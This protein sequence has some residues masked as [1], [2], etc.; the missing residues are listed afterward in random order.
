VKLI[1]AMNKVYRKISL[2]SFQGWQRVD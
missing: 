2:R 1:L